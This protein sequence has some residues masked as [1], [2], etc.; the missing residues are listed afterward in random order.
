MRSLGLSGLGI[1]RCFGLFDGGGLIEMR[2]IE[3]G[4]C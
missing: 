3:P 1:G 4:A 2:R